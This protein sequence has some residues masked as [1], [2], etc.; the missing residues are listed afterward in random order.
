MANL[1]DVRYEFAEGIVLLAEQFALSSIS[2]AWQVA[3]IGDSTTYSNS[4]KR[5]GFGYHFEVVRENASI[6]DALEAGCKIFSTTRTL[7]NR[8]IFEAYVSVLTSPQLRIDTLT[9]P[10]SAVANRLGRPLLRL[11]P[12]ARLQRRH[13]NRPVAEMHLSSQYRLRGFQN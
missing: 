9:R 3:A 6:G 1:C 7:G 11:H 4:A 5:R 8:K 2:R 12:R 10:I 13:R